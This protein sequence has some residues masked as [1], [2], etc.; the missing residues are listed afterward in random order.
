M[1]VVHGCA[2]FVPPMVERGT[3]H[4]VN[5]ASAAGY[6]ASP[7]LTAYSATKFAVL[8]L[9]EA[10]REELRPH[11]LGVTAICPGLINTPITMSSRTR[12]AASD[13]S[14][15]ER[16]AAMY[17]RRNYGPER[18]AR[19]I[20][21]AVHRDRTVAPISPEAWFGYGLKRISPRLVGWIT[22]KTGELDERRGH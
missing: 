6:L 4:V 3:G 21:K 15:R 13:P 8:G 18:V 14:R 5:V 2:L 10:L 9:S 20:L 22:R 1:G 19:N 11:G 16:V 12:G 17:A 7:Q